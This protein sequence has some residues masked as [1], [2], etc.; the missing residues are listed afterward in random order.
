MAY[1]TERGNVTRVDAEISSIAAPAFVEASKALAHVALQTF[2]SNDVE[3]FS[4]EGSFTA[5]TLSESAGYS[6]D[7]G[8]EYSET[9]TDVTAQTYAHIWKP[10]VQAERFAADRLNPVKMG[11]K[12]ADAI[13]RAV[14][15]TWLALFSGFTGNT[16]I[17]AGT[18]MD[19]DSLLDAQVTVHK[20]LNRDDE[21]HVV[22]SR[23]Q[24]ND[25]RK[26]LTD[27]EASAFTREAMLQTVMR[28]IQPNGYVGDFSDMKIFNTSGLPTSGGDTLGL[29]FHPNYAFAMAYDPTFYTRSVFAG[30]SGLFTEVATWLFGN[31]D[32]WID[33]AGCV[34][35]A[36]T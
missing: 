13:S 28:P 19:K 7:A 35:K 24:R 11:A 5:G 32:E 16:A 3:R 14:D 18:A 4:Q 20:A 22:M 30:S 33:A 23:D 2:G 27:T 8:D 25:I 9:D 31:V 1:E 6:Y 15:G 17:D 29:C 36:D 34:V 26:E 12:Q 21:L 10:T